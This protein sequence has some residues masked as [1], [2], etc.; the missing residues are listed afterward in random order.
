MLKI[1]ME[2]KRGVLFV[3]LEGSFNKENIEKFNNDVIPVILKHGL[4]FVVV[5]LDKV[6]TLDINGI[7]SLME[8]N[9]IV[10]KYDGK[11]TLCSLTNKKVQK[12]LRES[13]YSDM[14]YET[15]N[16]LTAIGVMKL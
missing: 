1:D 15:S 4:K 16:E 2:F 3:R 13:T 12:S 6:N 8:L 14:F 9:E 5:N 10:S 7:E 11:T